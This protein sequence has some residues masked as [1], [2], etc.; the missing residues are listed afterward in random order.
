MTDTSSST[1]VLRLR[2]KDRHAPKLRE[3]AGAVNLVW[4]FCNELSFR[5]LQREHRWASSAELQ[6]YLNGASKE[7]LAVGS[8]VFQQVAEEYVTRRRQ[9]KKA[10]LRWRVSNPQR[11]NYS[12]GWI[13]FK[14][15][16]LAYRAG[17]VVF[18]GVKLSL[19]DS[20]G[21][22][23]YELG[24]GSL[25]EDARGRWYL[26]VCVKVKKQAQ[27]LDRTAVNASA[28]GIDLG[29]K[30][31][32]ASSDGA[33]VEAEQFYRDLE[34]AL[35]R[36]QRAGRKDRTRAIHAKIANR[37]KDFLHKL[38]TRLVKNHRAI[39]VGDVDAQK[40]SQ[41]RMAKSVL[42]AGWSTFRTML[43]YKCDDA[44]V[45]FKPIDEKFSTQECSCCGAR[46]GPKGLAGLGT[47]EWTCSVCGAKHDRDTNSA[48]VI[49]ARGLVWL[50]KEFSAAVEARAVEAAVNEVAGAQALVAA[51]PGHGRPNVGIPVL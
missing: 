12:L 39:F 51:A 33:K 24:S 44:G 34:P 19:W 42:D 40:L 32:L 37:R 35:A 16:S 7:G 9:F 26:N 2:L 31:F 3:M 23:D 1:R 41:T 21:L 50:E 36:S 17:Q 27:A 38:S 22:A 48:S 13:P 15:R 46:A 6:R 49:K 8:A 18:Q 5:V 14:T 11:S 45:W 47:R 30:D 29:L 43:Q 25:S 20:Y 4:N 28:V 10:K